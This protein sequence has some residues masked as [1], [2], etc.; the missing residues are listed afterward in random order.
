MV[1]LILCFI[2]F[3]LI[4]GC[5]RDWTNA[6]IEKRIYSDGYYFH[7]PEKKYTPVKAYV[8]PVP[9]PTA[10]VGTVIN[11]PVKPVYSVTTPDSTPVFYP[12]PY[13]PPP[14]VPIYTYTFI[15]VNDSVGPGRMAG[16]GNVTGIKSNDSIPQKEHWATGTPVK[17]DSAMDQVVPKQDT[18]H[19]LAERDTLLTD[20]MATFTVYSNYKNRKSLDGETGGFLQAGIIS[21]PKSEGLPVQLN[22]FSIAMGIRYKIKVRSWNKLAFDFGYRFHQ[23]YIGQNDP[24]FFPLSSAAHDRERISVN[25]FSLGIADR[26]IYRADEKNT[27]W[28]DLGVCSDASFRTSNVYVDVINDEA[29]PVA[30]KSKVTTKNVHLNYLN[31]IN[32]SLTMRAGW[33]YYAVFAT[34]RL[35]DL[36]RRSS[37]DNNGDLPALVIGVE[38]NFGGEE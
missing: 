10:N 32:Y 17:T 38:L 26:F 11:R 20:T 5:S 16:G 14:P 7:V 34:W 27:Y 8:P 15:P 4:A 36:V 18:T 1:R 33:N 3:F 23:F 9:Y 13:N 24:K 22:S 19:S 31:K 29:S 37:T 6:V 2:A 35:S 30:D 21:G 12:R 28:L 25:N